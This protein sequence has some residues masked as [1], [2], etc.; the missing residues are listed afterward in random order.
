VFILSRIRELRSAGLSTRQA[1]VDGIA[2]SGGVV[3]SAALIMVAVFSILASLSVISLQMI[4]VGLAA[5]VLIDATVVRGVLLPAVLALLGERSWYLPR[6]LAR[7]LP[8]RTPA[9]LPAATP[10]AP[11]LAGRELADH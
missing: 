9:A 1:T 8:G 7:I 11:A 6:W 4:G 5:A 3:S 2:S 10:A